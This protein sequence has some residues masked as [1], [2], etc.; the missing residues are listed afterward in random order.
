MTDFLAH[1]SKNDP[2]LVTINA[3][4]KALAKLEQVLSEIVPGTVS[5]GPEKESSY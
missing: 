5:P 1:L 3:H 4:Q 2:T